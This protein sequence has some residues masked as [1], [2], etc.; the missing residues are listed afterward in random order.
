MR[1]KLLVAAS[2]LVALLTFLLVPGNALAWLVRYY[3]PVYSNY[4]YNVLANQKAVRLAAYQNLMRQAMYQNALRAAAYQRAVRRGTDQGVI[5]RVSPTLGSNSVALQLLM[6]Q[7]NNVPFFGGR[8]IQPFGRSD[9]G[10]Q[11]NDNGNSVP[12]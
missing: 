3:G 5:P 4:N 1:A 8:A 2:F 7:L 6:R 9:T 11:L 12:N 10:P